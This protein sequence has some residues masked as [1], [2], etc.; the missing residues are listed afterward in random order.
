MYVPMDLPTPRLPQNHSCESSYVRSVMCIGGLG[1]LQMISIAIILNEI[2]HFSILGVQREVVF[3]FCYTEPEVLAQ[4]GYFA[5]TPKQPR[6]AFQFQVL[7]LLEAL[8]L[9]CQVALKDFTAA[10]ACLTRSPLLQVI[11]CAHGHGEHVTYLLSVTPHTEA[12]PKGC[13]THISSPFGFF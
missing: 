10:L 11:L 5:A 4:H 3:S 9:E 12:V 2:G 1:G 8:L 6:L 13:Y 7:D